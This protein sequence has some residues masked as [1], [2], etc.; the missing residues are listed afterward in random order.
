MEQIDVINQKGEVVNNFQLNSEIWSVPLSRYN[1]SLSNR[2]YLA[3][4]RQGTKKTKK[5]GE[6]SGGGIKPWRQTL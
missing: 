1:I 6:V 5:K 2:Y 3:N 4:Q